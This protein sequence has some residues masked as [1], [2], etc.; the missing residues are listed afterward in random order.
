MITIKYT[1]Q[2]LNLKL[3]TRGFWERALINYLLPV[4][5]NL[6]NIITFDNIE[7]DTKDLGMKGT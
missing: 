6:L 7:H 2:L 1:T 4:Q 5:I 3:I